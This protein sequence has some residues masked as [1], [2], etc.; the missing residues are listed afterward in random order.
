MLNLTHVDAARLHRTVDDA[1]TDGLAGRGLLPR[2]PQSEDEAVLAVCATLGSF[3]HRWNAV[4]APYGA[5][6]TMRG[7]FIHH[8]PQVEF[9]DANGVKAPCEL[10]D[11]LLLVDDLRRGHRSRHAVIT[12]AKLT[13]GTRIVLHGNKEWRQLDLNMRWPPFTFKPRD[14]DP[15]KT[16][17]FRHPAAPPGHVSL[18][19]AYGG[20]DIA[21]GIWEQITP[22]AAMGLGTGTSLA[23]T[24]VGMVEGRAGRAAHLPPRGGGPCPDDWSEVVRLLMARSF[25]RTTSKRLGATK[26]AWSYFFYDDLASGLLGRFPAEPFEDFALHDVAHSWIR[27]EDSLWDG[28]GAPPE[29]PGADGDDDDGGTSVFRIAIED[30]EGD[31]ERD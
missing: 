31:A 12:Q 7:A 15:T 2:I 10:G 24:V 17:D 8:T 29:T 28:D 22:S 14:Y 13:T 3:K 27:F 16:R 19:S 26:R 30:V 11:L 6:V 4:L 5:K 1:V 25:R 18:S 21:A 20:I 23:D 9:T